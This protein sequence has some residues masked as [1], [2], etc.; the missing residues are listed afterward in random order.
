MPSPYLPAL[1]LNLRVLSKFW[2][3][4]VPGPA[5]AG[6]SHVFSTDPTTFLPMYKRGHVGAGGRAEKTAWLV[7][8]W[9]KL[10]SQRKGFEARS[11][12]YGWAIVGKAAKGQG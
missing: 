3:W 2:H 8:N 7:K 5:I 6:H 11:G 12:K 9:R 1:S 4:P 10:G